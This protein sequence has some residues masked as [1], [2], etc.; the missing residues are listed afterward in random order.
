MARASGSTED[1]VRLRAL[2]DHLTAG[3]VGTTAVL[4]LRDP[5]SPATPVR[6]V[7]LRRIA[8]ALPAERLAKIA[9]PRPG[10]VYLNPSRFSNDELDAMLP[11]LVAA[12]GIVVDVRDYPHPLFSDGRLLPLLSDSPIRAVGASLPYVTGPDGRMTLRG[13][14][15]DETPPRQ[16]RLRARV[17]F[18][19]GPGAISAAESMLGKVEANRL[20]PIV[21]APTAG[22]NGM[23]HTFALP[24]GY[25][26]TWTGFRVRRFDGSHFHGVGVRPTVPAA[27]TLRGLREGR[28]EVLERALELVDGR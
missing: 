17:V 21:G 27:P 7:R 14:A 28:D 22:T 10:I 5:L 4:R 9:E 12:R 13:G 20:G 8:T 11:R 3:A 15:E 6:E 2:R 18:L 26:V 24:A 25:L 23:V 16:P 1:R 19:S